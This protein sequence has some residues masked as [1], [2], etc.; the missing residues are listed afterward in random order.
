MT[1]HAHPLPSPSAQYSGKSPVTLQCTSTADLLAALPLLTGFTDQR[2]LFVV[3]FQGRRGGNVLRLEL[4][5][6]QS[7]HAVQTLV[8]GLVSLL[9]DTGAGSAGPAIV[10]AT[11]QRFDES[12]G[13][14]WGRLAHQLKRGF[15]REGWRLR[16]LAVIAADGWSS[17]IAEQPGVRRPLS[18]VAQ[19]KFADA[20]RRPQPRRLSSLGLL[21]SPDPRYRAAIVQCLA[22]L[23][24]Q[25]LATGTTHAPEN[26]I[27]RVCD[28]ARLAESCFSQARSSVAAGVASPSPLGI[29]APQMAALI[30][31]A[32]SQASWVI[33][34][35]TALTRAEFVRHLAEESGAA[36]LADIRLGADP[37]AALG[38]HPDWSIRHLLCSL[39]QD[40][41]EPEQLRAAVA[42]L[43]G[44]TAHAPRDFRPA[45][46]AMLAW[47]W[48]MLGMQSIATRMVTQSFEIDEG[49]ALTQMVQGLISR[50]PVRQLNRLRA[51]FGADSGSGSR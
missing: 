21:A 40:L 16:E 32:Q 45:L 14:P 7:R 38:T 25:R 4:P 27:S 9:R 36:R 11:D 41:P 37:D 22:D 51:E 8:D 39:A 42:V 35:L 15:H 23:R 1:T 48:W 6:T 26:S 24:R 43:E 30:E 33:V 34:A 2:S 12:V 50:P 31:S 19:S 44:A 29:P 13:P 46:F 10:I 18:E 3:L 20:S 47:A 49:H 5:A 28:T 17:L